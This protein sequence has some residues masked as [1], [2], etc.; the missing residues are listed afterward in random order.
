MRLRGLDARPQDLARELPILRRAAAEMG[1]SNCT[2]L[3][4]KA[5]EQ[6]A[7][8]GHLDLGTA[9]LKASFG[10]TRQIFLRDLPQV[11]AKI[12]SG[13]GPPRPP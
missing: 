12:P 3:C 1:F 2:A 9:A 7:R 8:Q 13:S 4:R 5:E 11:M 6:L 10:Y